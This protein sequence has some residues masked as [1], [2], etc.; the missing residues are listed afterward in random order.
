MLFYPLLICTVL[1]IDLTGSQASR[2]VITKAIEEFN[3]HTCVK[4][5]PWT[6]EANYVEFE[7]GAGYVGFR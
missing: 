7:N 2:E 1:K 4:W 5:I 3:K 6:G